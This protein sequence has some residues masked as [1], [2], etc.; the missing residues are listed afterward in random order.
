S[1][2]G[3]DF[4]KQFAED[5]AVFRRYAPEGGMLG[6]RKRVRRAQIVGVYRLLRLAGRVKGGQRAP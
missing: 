5:E 6:L 1:K 3:A 4:E 2:S